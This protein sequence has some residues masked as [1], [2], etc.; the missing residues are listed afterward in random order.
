LKE[1]EGGAM[2]E[3]GRAF[4]ALGSDQLTTMD[5]QPS[6]LACFMAELR[7]RH[8]FRVAVGYAAFAFV[9]LQLGEIVLPAFS[10]EWALQLVV[11]FTILGF[12]VVMALAWVFDITSEGIQVTDAMDGEGDF[13]DRT[14]AG[15]LPRL[16]FLVVTLLAVGGVGSW[17]TLNTVGGSD[18][19]TSVGGS[20]TPV[21]YD[22]GEAIRSL[23]VLPLQNFSEDAEQDYFAA[24]MHEALL[25]RLSQLPE[26]RVVSRTSVAQY[27]A[28]DKTVP[29][30]AR[31][32]GVEAIVEGSV[33]RAGD[34]VRITVQ[35][36]HGAS[37]TH[38]WAQSYERGFS[39]V[40]AL[41]SEVADAIAHEIKGPLSTAGA[42]P[43][44]SYTPVSEVPGA[45]EA[46]MRARFE[47]SR[48]TPEGLRAAIEQYS[49]ALGEDPEF[50]GAYAGLAGAELLLGM[51]Q[52]SDP[53]EALGRARVLALKAFELDPELP[54]AHD[55]LALIEE[56]FDEGV[57]DP[58]SASDQGDLMTEVR[59][60]RMSSPENV[61][62]D[63]WSGAGP[64][65]GP[66]TGPGAPDAV[67]VISVDSALVASAGDFRRDST[68]ILDSYTPVGSQLRAASAGWASQSERMA[69]EDP[70]RLVAA[71]QRLK[72]TGRTEEA[73][74]ILNQV[75]A[76]SPDHEEAW[77]ALELLYASTGEYE[78]ILD[79]RRMWVE[80]TEGDAESVD[81]L[82]SRLREDGAEGY[83][84]W[85]LDVLREQAAE[86]ELVSP[87]YLAAAQAGV[88]DT[89]GAM[90]SL[91]Q[92][93]R[94]R[95]RRLVSLR[96]DPVWD[97]MRSDRRFSSPLRGL[98]TPPSS[99]RFR[100]R[101]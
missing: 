18:G 41:Q 92:A 57:I 84:E 29:E 19:L 37:D 75:C 54:E 11:V 31:E 45:T 42:T 72:A 6:R 15:I 95:D 63:V 66:G 81:R 48:E 1:G 79:L 88:G 17:W 10:A 50:A 85:R 38:I 4:S 21:A 26:V 9:V 89:E 101:N 14:A 100:P 27:A 2:L 86:G 44:L 20:I 94:D 78:E 59:V 56:Q 5:E 71:A 69:S 7:R 60:V 70:A 73:A 87:V 55:I 58:L 23:A 80:F 16:A 3:V 33:F 67:T 39:D 64:G 82:E 77:E 49:R 91:R 98:T 65:A 22:P 90:A 53:T 24:G 35:L 34:Q 76:I 51:S 96:T 61:G 12:P 43:M 30:I 46:F 40:L 47:Q 93:V 74:E 36:I 8:V 83:W 25:E 52:S 13:P 97:V 68:A 32:L 99:R 28:T 62:V